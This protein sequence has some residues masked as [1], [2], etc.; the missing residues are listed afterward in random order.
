M[1]GSHQDLNIPQFSHITVNYLICQ[2]IHTIAFFSKMS[3]YEF[4]WWH[5]NGSLSKTHR[6]LNKK[7]VYSIWYG[8]LAHRICNVPRT[9]IPPHIE[10][11]SEADLLCK[12]HQRNVNSSTAHRLGI[13][14]LMF[15]FTEKELLKV[16][17]YIGL[18]DSGLI[19]S[20]LCKTKRSFAFSSLIPVYVCP[21]QHILWPYWSIPR[22]IPRLRGQ[23]VVLGHLSL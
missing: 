6:Y 17:Q 7:M 13:L 5:E 3:T 9:G 23:G 20:G 1:Y 19:R 21:V 4:S 11:L 15:P 2:K 8:R 10:N 18:F 12:W 14:L 16:G 22:F